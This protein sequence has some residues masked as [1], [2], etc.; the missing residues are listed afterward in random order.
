MVSG[1]RAAGTPDLLNARL[2]NEKNT[3]AV[4]TGIVVRVRLFADFAG[5]G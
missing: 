4:V 1:V 3:A 5:A 2:M